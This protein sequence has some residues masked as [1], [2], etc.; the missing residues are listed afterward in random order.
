LLFACESEVSIEDLNEDAS[1]GIHVSYTCVTL[2]D[3]RAVHAFRLCHTL[4]YEVPWNRCVTLVSHIAEHWY[5]LKRASNSRCSFSVPRSHQCLTHCRTSLFQGCLFVCAEHVCFPLVAQGLWLTHVWQLCNGSW[6]ITRGNRRRSRASSRWRTSWRRYIVNT[7]CFQIGNESSR[8]TLFPPTRFWHLGSVC[9]SVCLFVCRSG[10]F[11]IFTWICEE[12]LR[13]YE[14]K[15]ISTFVKK[16]Q[17]VNLTI[18]NLTNLHE[19]INE[20]KEKPT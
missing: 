20:P 10:R 1:S 19:R 2:C 13:I 4:Q 9:L 16:S 15:K 8:G 6:T 3:G 12:N 7:F 11:S 5:H 14:S 18:S 17:F